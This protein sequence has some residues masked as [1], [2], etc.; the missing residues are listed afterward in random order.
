MAISDF[1]VTDQPI[2]FPNIR[3]AYKGKNLVIC[4]DAACVWIDLELFGCRDNSDRGR[5]WKMGWHFMTINKLVEVFPGN[6]EHAYS[7]SGEFLDIFV[8]ARRREYK[9]EFVGPNHTHAAGRGSRHRWPWRGSGSSSLGACL[10]AIQMGYDRIVLAGIPLDDS[11]HNGE[12]HWRKCRF[13]N[14]VQDTK[15]HR[16]I[17]HHWKLARDTVFEGKVTSLSGRTR[18]W[19]GPPMAG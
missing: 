10:S 11:A 14:E 2:A 6:I 15:S 8:K 12:P 9:R 17:N 3:G 1:L 18:D 13:R 7:N 19:L 5:V 4:G 16:T